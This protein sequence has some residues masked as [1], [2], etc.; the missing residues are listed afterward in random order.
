MPRLAS[1]TV[2]GALG[3]ASFAAC[4]TP[5]QT[6]TAAAAAGPAA[7]R[8]SVE[9]ES[10][11]MTAH[12]EDD[13]RCFDHVCLRP[14][15]SV[16]GDYHAALGQRLREA[17]DLPSALEAYAEALRSY[18]ADKLAVPPDI[19]CAYGGA[20]AS[21]RDNKERAELAAR[22]LHRCIS[23]TPAG[24]ALHARA[25]REITALDE[26]G[27]DPAHLARP[28]AAD[29]YLTKAPAKPR[30]D[31]LTVTVTAEPTPTAKGWAE[32]A[33]AI[34]AARAALVPCWDASY[35]AK[36]TPVLAVAVP[37]RSKYRPSA[38]D[39]EPGRWLTAIE[40]KFDLSG[41]ES[42]VHDA[43]NGALKAVK[44]DGEWLATV[45]VTVK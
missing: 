43:V 12:C 25:L 17:G 1:I 23:S 26:S 40:G 32:T 41:P 18:E 6:S 29:L 8:L 31:E 9:L 33:A 35:A 15:R 37:I 21:G 45:T 38:Y 27:L 2:L 11:G 7:G 24:A 30:K 4:D 5:A 28:Q 22:V 14:E 13:L 19:D 10:C 36:K 39:D 44:G 34:V 3:V 20:L 16:L 42:C